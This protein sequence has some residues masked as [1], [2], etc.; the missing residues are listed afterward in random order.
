V[1]EEACKE[2]ITADEVTGAVEEAVVVA[3][4]EEA[5]EDVASDVF[6]PQHSKDRST[7]A[8]QC[9]TIS[10]V[11]FEDMQRSFQ[12]A[13]ERLEPYTTCLRNMG[14]AYALSLSRSTKTKVQA[15]KA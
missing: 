2:G 1:A 12:L 9:G 10:R 5:D 8:Q 15:W 6:S 4:G 3:A 11:M 14:R 13:A 7:H